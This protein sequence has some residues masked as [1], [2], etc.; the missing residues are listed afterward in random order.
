MTTGRKIFKKLSLLGLRHISFQFKRQ[1]KRSTRSAFPSRSSSAQVTYAKHT[2]LPPARKSQL[3]ST[4]AIRKEH[5]PSS[6]VRVATLHHKCNTRRSLSP[7]H[8]IP[9][10]SS[11]P[12]RKA[13]S[14]SATLNIATLQ[15]KRNARST[16]SQ[17]QLEN[18]NSSVQVHYAK[19]TPPALGLR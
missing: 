2:F 15:C 9:F 18:R 14:P 5:S 11:S 13:R 19:Y 12:A 1:V 10:P 16:L 7:V 17:L 8:E 4:S 3:F 6:R